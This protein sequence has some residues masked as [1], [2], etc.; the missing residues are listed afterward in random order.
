VNSTRP[1]ILIVGAGVAGLTTALAL[2][3]QGASVVVIDRSQ[4]GTEASWAGGGILCPLYAW[5]YPEAVMALARRGMREYPALLDSLDASTDA[6]RLV[7]GMQIL[8]PVGPG[9]SAAGVGEWLDRFGIRHEWLPGD[10]SPDLLLP[11]V[12]NVRNPRLLLALREAAESEGI[13]IHAHCAA[14]RLRLDGDRVTGV[15]T[16]DGALAA[17]QVV[18]AAGAWSEALTPGASQGSIFPVRGQML[19]LEAR[20]ENRLER[21]LMDAGTYLIPRRDGSVVIGSTVEYAG[22]DKAVDP[23]AQAALHAKACRLWPPLAGAAIT[24]RWAG[25]RPGS[26]DEIPILGAHPHV[27][28]LW[29]NTGGFRNGLAMAPASASLLSDLMNDHPPALD[30]SPY[31]VGRILA[32]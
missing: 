25:L 28:G 18:I 22:F 31:R 1:D 11:D 13:T 15:I 23:V 27:D 12:A 2:R 19:R 32:D 29:L 20:P 16:A 10:D 30:P 7:T 24:H 5:R 4:P 6:E 3:R 17:G 26:V 8:D 14:D 21:I 9:E